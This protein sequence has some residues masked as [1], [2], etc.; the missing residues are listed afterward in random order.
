MYID[1]SVSES[2]PSVMFYEVHTE[3]E[4]TVEPRLF[5]IGGSAEAE[6][7]VDSIAYVTP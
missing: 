7:T 5:S 6:E 4:E 1:L 3:A 2:D